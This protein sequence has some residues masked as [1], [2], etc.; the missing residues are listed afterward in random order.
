MHVRKLRTTLLALASLT[1]AVAVA[2]PAWAET[3]C[4]PINAKGEGAITSQ[5]L[6]EV[7]TA[8]QI[9]GG[10]IIHGTTTAQLFPTSFDPTT[11][12]E[13]FVGTLV[14]TT[15]NGTL[16]LFIFNGVFDT[17]TG[18]FSND[19]M[20]V[21]GTGRFAG[22]TGGLFFHG[23]VAADGTFTDDEI[24]GEICLEVP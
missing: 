21:D 20:V 22:A 8:S 11:G 6:T 23:F 9:I 13:T 1:F 3:V 15:Q 14:L 4:I 12:I 17:F 18:E 19:S 24:S 2:G 7:D 5:S 16:T 10:G